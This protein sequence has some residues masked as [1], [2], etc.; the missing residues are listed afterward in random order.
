[1][2]RCPACSGLENKVVDS[3]TAD[4][5]GAIRRRR[6]CLDC[7]RRFTTYERLEE[8][9][10]VVLKRTGQREQ[11]D[12]TKI[13]A[14]IRSAAKNR[15]VSPEQMELLGAEVEEGL[16]LEGPEVTT[17]QIG[18]A[19]LDRLRDLDEVVYL[20]FVSVYKGFE[21]LTDFEREVVL[22][23]RASDRNDGERSGDR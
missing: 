1:V 7:G 11:F 23:T 12:R 13:V 9:S 22:L 2:V 18:R 14:G 16:R 15:P 21:D 10:L 19:V 8:A 5:G 20:R 6:E 17:E 4:D 3:R